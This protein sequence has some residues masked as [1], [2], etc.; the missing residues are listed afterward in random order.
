M[1]S[2]L[3]IL[4]ST[5]VY[6]QDRVTIHGVVSAS[7]DG[8][9]LPGVTVLVKGSTNGA[10]TDM[11]GEFNIKAASTATLSFSF[12]G[13]K[14]KDVLVGQQ[15]SINV[16]LDEDVAQLNEVVVVGYG[17]VKKSSLTGSVSKVNN[18]K[19]DQIPTPRVEEALQGQISGVN[20]QM[21]DPQAG[22]APKVQVR[23]VGSIAAD[24]SPLVVVDGMVVDSDYMASLDMN[25]VESI[26]VLKDASSA[27]IYGSRGGNGV[28][29]I[30]TKGGQEG[31]AKFAFNAY[32]GHKFV[33]KRNI[34]PSIAQ[35]RT[36]ANNFIAD[37]ENKLANVDN[38]GLA[39]PSGYADVLKSALSAAK[40][41]AGEYG[42]YDHMDLLGTE[43]DWQ[44][45]FF[46]GGNI[47]SYNLS[48]SGGTE[49]TKY[50][51]SGGY[52]SDDGVLLTDSYKKMNLRL[53]LKT[54]LTDKLEMGMNINPSR[55]IS[56]AFPAYMYDA[57]RSAPWLPQYFD[58]HTFQF[59]DHKKYPNAAIGDYAFEKPF[60]NYTDADGNKYQ[61]ISTT[62]NP[63]ALA[64]VLERDKK[65]YT[66][67]IFANTYLQY[68]LL[69]GLNFKTTLSSTYRG[70]VRDYWAGTKYHRDGAAKAE[71]QYRAY[72]YLKWASDSYFSYNL[73]KGKHDLSAVLG[74]SFEHI[75]DEFVEARMKG[76][77]NDY[78][79]TGEGGSIISDATSSKVEESLQSFF[80]RVNYAYNDK[81]LFSFSLRT[82]GSSKFG[83]N[84]QYGIFPAGSFGWRLS[85]ENFMKALPWVNNLKA[86]ISYGVTGNNSGISEYEHL[87]MLGQSSAVFGNNISAGF[88]PMNIASPDLRW[89]K[90]LELNPGIDFGFFGN[91]VYG[92]LDWYQRLSQDLLL[93][94]EIPSQ[95][96]FDKTI[97]NL[98]SVKNQG[99][100]FELTA[101]PVVTKDFE[102]TVTTNMSFNKNELTGFGGVDSLISVYDPKR[103][104][105]WIAVVGQPIASYYGYKVDHTRSIPTEYLHDPFSRIGG[106][107]QDVYV[108]DLN[109]DGKITTADRTILGNDFPTFVWSISNSFKYK[110]WDLSIMWQGNAGAKVRNIDPVYFGNHFASGMDYNKNAF[111]DHTKNPNLAE[112]EGRNWVQERIYTD[113]I[114]QDASYIA[115]RN[116]NI[117]YKLP[118]TFVKKIGLTSC[119]I[120]AAGTNLLYFMANGY[121]SWN[122]EGVYNT[123]N[124]LTYGYQKGGAP[125]PRSY[126]VGF[127]IEF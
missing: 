92:S 11:N 82:D 126:T 72:N 49:H 63:S 25:D 45:V 9:A 29:M 116:V 71:D 109:G 110:N 115:L 108:Q 14:T 97:V 42:R 75:S 8:S 41:A 53:N 87:A 67:K 73:T 47:Q 88:A 38:L 52:M 33:K 3:V 79:K 101:R 125:L 103:P 94:R 10:I 96:G 20:I 50:R 30:T 22:A 74:T 91:R 1:A 59:I 57:M 26:S 70:R 60:D 46:D 21:S 89:E 86:R 5:A 56:R 118:K 117:G 84:Y 106:Q 124:P 105:E 122:P 85:E 19:L 100:E 61:N 58:E 27:A 40:K 13:Y 81:Y 39:D 119:R 65:T 120:Y 113:D 68:K 24:A 32:F 23:G 35:E 77:E 95:T 111:T 90:Q 127:N 28:I 123:D 15:T 93:P 4:L 17:T 98:G 55:E 12:I 48:A 107:S 34:Y 7:A 44:D 102:W 104:A 80:G 121:S 36:R 76:Y 69:K 31:K 66:N 18:D 64:A 6:A 78:I 37:A 62:S 54:K 16:S 43:H 99:V 51:I 112:N 2:L 83:E 114:I